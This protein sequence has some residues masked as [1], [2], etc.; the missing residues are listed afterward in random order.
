MLVEVHDVEKGQVGTLA[1]VGFASGPAPPGSARGFGRICRY[2][3]IGRVDSRTGVQDSGPV[4]TVI[5]EWPFPSQRILI[6]G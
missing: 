1:A 3:H 6:P 5:R 4:R 2:L